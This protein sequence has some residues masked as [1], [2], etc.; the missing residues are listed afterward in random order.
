MGPHQGKLNTSPC[1]NQISHLSLYLR[2]ERL[3]TNLPRCAWMRVTDR[4]WSCWS[5]PPVRTSH[6]KYGSL[7][8][9]L[10]NITYR[11]TELQNSNTINISILMQDL[12]FKTIFYCLLLYYIVKKLNTF[13]KYICDIK[14]S[15]FTGLPFD[16]AIQAAGCS[17]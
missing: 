1:C 10:T 15:L 5:L 16:K 8:T 9:T 12:I 2:L 14:L 6:H 4:A 17:L 3:F 13:S 7:T 11:T